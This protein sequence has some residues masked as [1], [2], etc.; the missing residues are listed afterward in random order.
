MVI[1]RGTNTRRTVRCSRDSL[2]AIA[3]LLAASTNPARAVAQEPDS[4]IVVR[5][6]SV[7]IRLVDVEVRAAV[8]ALAQY[9]DRPVVFGGMGNASGA[10]VSLETPQPV[11]R[12]QV[13]DLLRGVLE[14]Q[15]LELFA[16]TSGSVPGI[17]R[18]RGRDTRPVQ[19]R[20]SARQA[21]T[22]GRLELFV[23]KLAH[24]RAADVAAT[25]SALYGRASALGELGAQPPTLQ[26]ELRENRVPPGLQQPADAVTPV[27]VRSAELAG[28]VTIVP[29]AR[30]NS[31]LIRASPDD[32]SLIQAAVQQ[33]DVRPLQVL[34]EVVIAEVRRDKSFSFGVET[35]LPP[36]RVGGSANTVI[37]GSTT[38]LGLSDFALKVMGIGGVDL[39]A[40]LRAAAARGDVRIMSRPIVL[41]ANNETA[42]ILV[43]SQRPFVQVQRALPTDAGVRDQIVQYKDVGTQLTVRPTI[44]AEGYVTLEVTQEVNTATSEVAFDAPVISTRSVQTRL[45]V[46][47]SQTVVLGGLSDRQREANQGG[48]PVLSSI[49]LLGGLFGRAS[50]RT[51]ET[52]LFI[53]L[54]PR[55]IRS[56]E[57]ARDTTTPIQE[58]VRRFEP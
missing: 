10:R 45:L 35:R 50:R 55:I 57:D 27:G 49:P 20:E 31:L 22:G 8:Q 33:V 15:G 3:L 17:Y 1:T 29:D 6:D 58:R 46:R 26:D 37:Q 52:E 54:T 2:L 40:T 19:G 53:F 21:Q 28:E 43:G 42:D 34:I 56:D 5:N 12:T 38:G 9:L 18:V 51:S 14:S 11:P 44:S 23:I 32:Y 16:D 39:D 13:V 25:V 41:A 47:D 48:V 30:T 36:Q 4:A 24:A 7:S